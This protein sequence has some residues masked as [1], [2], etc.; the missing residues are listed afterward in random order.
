M[1][2]SNQL[3]EKNNH[4][5]A[6][7]TIDIEKSFYKNHVLKGISFGIK[8]GE[9]VGLVGSNGAGKS[10]LMKIIN[11]V[12]KADRGTVKINGEPVQ[13]KDAQGARKS[14]IAMVYQ[15]FSLVPTMTVFQNLFLSNEPRKGML[16]D[17]ASCIAQ[18]QKA[19]EDFNVDIDPKVYVESLSIGNQQIVEIVKALLQNPSVLILDEPTASLTQKEIVQLFNFIAKLKQ[20]GMAVILISHHLQEIMDLCD[21]VVVLRDG[22]VVMDDFVKNVEIHEIIQAMIGRRLSG[23][24][25]LAPNAAIARTEPLLEI[26]DMAW[27]EKLRDISFE[28]YPGEI[29][30][31]AGLL[32][33]GRTEILKN[34]YGLLECESGSIRVKGQPLKRQRPWTSIK[35]G[36]FLVPENRRKS[37]II[38]GQSIKSNILLPVWKRMRKKLFIDEQ[39]SNKIASDMVSRLSVKTVSTEQFVERLSGGNQQK[40]VFA[41][42]LVTE[43]SVLLLD[44]PTVGI[45]IE[46]KNEIARLI[47]DISDHGNGVLLV[48]SEMEELARLSDRVLVLKQGKIISELSRDRGDEITEEK[49]AEAIQM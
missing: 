38:A 6:M 1:V 39:Q 44:D 35:N 26:R 12:Y 33:S 42:S 9:V 24:E 19:F 14:G 47:R 15:E 23:N 45:D 37:G 32:G 28:V 10:T 4:S 48:S 34:I 31:I 3:D 16:I 36:L 20:Q 13:Y 18:A 2:T 11:G 22:S 30:G 21:R 41:K 27:G 7:E 25:Y 17:D 49:L 46:A 5:Y 43:P 40:V 8:K 29:L